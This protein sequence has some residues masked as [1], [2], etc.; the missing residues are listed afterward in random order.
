MSPVINPRRIQWMQTGA[1]EDFSGG[2]NIRDAPN[3]LA[4]N[5]AEDA[6]NVTMD[7]R[8]GVT[9]R[10]GYI[11]ANTNPF[12]GGFIVNLFYSSLV[13]NIITQAG[14][15]LYLGASAVTNHTFTT[16][17]IVTF[18]EFGGK[19]LALHPHDG[20]FS[21]PDAVTWTQ[22]TAAYAPAGASF[23]SQQATCIATWQNKVWV[24][25]TDGSL[26][27]SAA[28]DPTTWASTDFNKVWEK[29]QQ[30]IVALHIG[31]G[32][33]ILGDAGLL[34]FKTESTYRVNDSSTGAYT[35]VD[36]T[37]GCAGPLAVT[38]VGP[39]VVTISRYGIFWWADGEVGMTD[40]TAQRFLPLWEGDQ[41]NFNTL[42]QWCAGRKANG[43]L[44]FSVTRI[45]ST[46]NNLAFE[47]HDAQQWIAPGSNAMTCYAT[48]T[49]G[50]D[51]LYG[52]S[53]TVSGIIYVLDRG[54]TDDGTAIT[55]RFQTRWANVTGGFLASIWRVN[56]HLRG[57]GTMAVLKDFESS[58][59]GYTFNVTGTVTDYDGG[60]DY[61]QPGIVYDSALLQQ[62]PILFYSI[63]QCRFVSFLFSGTS[64]TTY[65]TTPLLGGNVGRTQGAF[66]LFGIEYAFWWLGFKA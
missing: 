9:S 21:S 12:G 33:D 46:V 19:I 41:L 61:D 63:G 5:E 11:R 17:A 65:A 34:A 66:G 22:I 13:S 15:S 23:G 54:G 7:E 44:V 42:N 29:D 2:P 55:W 14:P 35:T 48:A 58:G 3:E 18:C 16:S 49:D 31:S 6:F 26:H 43:H 40:G 39:K 52:G 47:Y 25:C 60:V 30:P 64:S 51:S 45:G 50:S 1:L 32:Q 36:A 28:G 8:G 56:A 59:S 24:G 27:W 38:G 20:L 10:L 37:V 62:S 53:T 4:A 57:A